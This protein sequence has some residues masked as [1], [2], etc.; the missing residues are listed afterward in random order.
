MYRTT[1]ET[2]RPWFCPNCQSLLAM[3]WGDG[4][5]T[6]GTCGESTTVV[7]RHLNGPSITPVALTGTPALGELRTIRYS[8]RVS[9]LLDGEHLREGRVG[10]A[11]LLWQRLR[12]SFPDGEEFWMLTRL[13]SSE[14]LSSIA[15][16]HER[17]GESAF[18]GAVEAGLKIGD[19]STVGQQG[20]EPAD[21]VAPDARVAAMREGAPESPRRG[22]AVGEGGA[23][24][25]WSVAFDSCST[26]ERKGQFLAGLAFAYT[27]NHGSVP[28]W[29][30]DELESEPI[31]T[32][33][34]AIIARAL[35]ASRREEWTRVRDGNLELLPAVMELHALAVLL[36]ANALERLRD[37]ETA[38]SLLET[39][40]SSGGLHMLGTLGALRELLPDL[41]LCPHLWP[42]LLSHRARSIREEREGFWWILVAVV[43]TTLSFCMVPPLCAFAESAT[44]EHSW[45][46]AMVSHPW[47]DSAV[48]TFVLLTCYG[49]VK[50]AIRGA[51][52]KELAASTFVVGTTVRVTS[53]GANE[54][55]KL[56]R[57]VVDLPSG[58]RVDGFRID[59]ESWRV[60]RGTPLLIRIPAKE[61]PTLA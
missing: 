9:E 58:V 8:T 27:H 6:C 20:V 30:R 1:I 38:F 44:P 31:A 5:T 28:D 39:T 7:A 46:R 17:N 61:K 15:T 35:L 3:P 25:V 40:I 55:T 26:P 54:D 49:L 43:G 14:A 16:N 23:I 57:V 42:T 11:W 41:T 19:G 52:E 59:P 22:A 12:R 37:Y 50:R 29:V 32:V 2:T 18:L 10:E 4:V 45:V 24:A 36:K 33:P 13:L 21:P 34:A 53:P 56:D 47:I 51:R 48:L 60:Q